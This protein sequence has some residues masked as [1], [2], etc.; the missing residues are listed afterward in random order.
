M[1]TW[2]SMVPPTL[3][4]FWCSKKFGE[5]GHGTVAY[6]AGCIVVIF[7]M[8]SM[9][10]TCAF[11]FVTVQ[12]QNAK[13]AGGI[14]WKCICY[15]MISQSDRLYTHTVYVHTSSWSHDR[16]KNKFAKEWWWL[17]VATLGW[18][19]WNISLQGRY[20]HV[21]TD[22]TT[23]VRTKWWCWKW[24][25]WIY[26]LIDGIMSNCRRWADSLETDQNKIEKNVKTRYRHNWGIQ[27]VQ[28]LKSSQCDSEVGVSFK[29]VGG[30]KFWVSASL[31][32]QW[33]SLPGRPCRRRDYCPGGHGV[34]GNENTTH[35]RGC[36]GLWK[37]SR[38]VVG[39][40]HPFEWIESNIH[41][42]WSRFSGPRQHLYI[43]CLIVLENHF[44][45]G[46]WSSLMIGK[47]QYCIFRCGIDSLYFAILPWF[48]HPTSDYDQTSKSNLELGPESG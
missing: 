40:T 28:H 38:H 32:P 45:Q 18:A 7:D 31:C 20:I 22:R 46:L 1:V 12:R 44:S 5:V 24:I 42:T 36:L 17:A 14:L 11:G 25:F 15:H 39:M 26:Q 9:S 47:L 34:M 33:K 16:T 23:R 10:M 6:C 27:F 4:I 3:L 29:N 41:S 2:I 37:Q 43:Q 35:F 48:V 19:L 30:W 8:I 21:N 13:V